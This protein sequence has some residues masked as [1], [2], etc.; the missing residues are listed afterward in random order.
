VYQAKL[1]ELRLTDEE[2]QIVEDPLKKRLPKIPANE[3]RTLSHLTDNPDQFNTHLSPRI[4]TRLWGRTDEMRGCYIFNL[5]TD[6]NIYDD[7]I[8]LTSKRTKQQISLTIS[9]F[10]ENY[11]NGLYFT[12]HSH[13]KFAY[14]TMKD[15]V[16]CLRHVEEHIGPACFSV[17]LRQLEVKLL[18]EEKQYSVAFEDEDPNDIVYTRTECVYHNDAHS[19]IGIH[20]SGNLEETTSEP[21]CGQGKTASEIR[22]DIVLSLASTGEA[23]PEISIKMDIEIPMIEDVVIDDSGTDFEISAEVRDT[24]LPF[25]KRGVRVNNQVFFPNLNY[26]GGITMDYI[27]ARPTSSFIVIRAYLNA[28]CGRMGR[29]DLVDRIFRSFQQSVIAMDYIRVKY[30]AES[31]FTYQLLGCHLASSSKI[32][33]VDH[34]PDLTMRDTCVV[35]VH[36]NRPYMDFSLC[37]QYYH[38][39]S[40]KIIRDKISVALPVELYGDDVADMSPFLK[41]NFL[42]YQAVLFRLI[43]M[44]Y[45]YKK[46]NGNNNI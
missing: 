13:N 16:I 5:G 1:D 39:E 23:V 40:D 42:L 7:M 2:L 11:L 6:Y 18:V 34:D 12:G 10:V 3:L 46:R 20:D 24:I 32:I 25:C 35:R 8:V 38:D 14:H 27:E 33:L 21:I 9:T 19:F 29:M 22:T 37:Y 43:I 28:I 44:E 17:W 30:I 36:K 45:S 15:L 4:I 41:E 31:R 26:I